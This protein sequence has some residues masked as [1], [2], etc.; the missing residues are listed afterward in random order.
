MMNSP[1]VADKPEKMAP[2]FSLDEEVLPEIKDWKIGEKYAIHLDV[3]QIGADKGMGMD[4]KGPINARFKVLSAHVCKG[5]MDNADDTEENDDSE[6]S[7]GETETVT[8]DVKK[9]SPKN[10]KIAEALRRKFE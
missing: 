3:E 10:A 6:E 9:G 5:G 8:I 7:D 1:T 4:S 2:T